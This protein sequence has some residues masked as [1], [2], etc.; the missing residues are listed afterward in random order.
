MLCE[1]ATVPM[2]FLSVLPAPWHSQ[3][4]LSPLPSAYIFRFIHFLRPEE[5][6]G[7]FPCDTEGN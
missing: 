7:P 3:P 4:K 2:P 1:N 6:T 5:R